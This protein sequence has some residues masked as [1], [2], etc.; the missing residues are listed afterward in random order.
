MRS[1]DKTGSHFAASQVPDGCSW[2]GIGTK[3]DDK[4]NQIQTVGRTMVASPQNS[5]VCFGRRS[6]PAKISR[7]NGAGGRRKASR[8]SRRTLSFVGHKMGL[9]RADSTSGL[10]F[11]AILGGWRIAL[12]H[13]FVSGP[14]GRSLPASLSSG[15]NTSQALDLSHWDKRK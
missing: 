4:Q 3:N 12:S 1:S 5:L 13:F 15:R 14:R 11:L 7:Q 10:L 2:R 9:V 6:E 8:G